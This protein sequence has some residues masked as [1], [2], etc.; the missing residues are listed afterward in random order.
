MKIESK[1]AQFIFWNPQSLFTS[2]LRT[3]QARW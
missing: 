3:N 1:I 2:S